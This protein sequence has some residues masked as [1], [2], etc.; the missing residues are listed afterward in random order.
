MELQNK[1]AVVYSAG[2]S[3]GGAVSKAFATAGVVF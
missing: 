2:P 1:N 3:L